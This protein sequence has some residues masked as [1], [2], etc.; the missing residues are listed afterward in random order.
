MVSFVPVV[1][2]PTPTPSFGGGRVFQALS[3][4]L[5]GSH[6][7]GSNAIPENMTLRKVRKT[8]KPYQPRVH[9]ENK[10]KVL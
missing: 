3:W 5:L 1:S 6:V 7:Q 8:M 2:S 10:N 4:S 9:A